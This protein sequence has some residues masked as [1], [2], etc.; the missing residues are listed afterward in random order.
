MYV[1]LNQ[2]TKYFDMFIVKQVPD[3]LLLKRRNKKCTNMTCQNQEYKTQQQHTIIIIISAIAGRIHWKRVF[4][5]LT[6]YLKGNGR[7]N[8]VNMNM[9]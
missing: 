2:I 8:K 5:G 9:M 4:I 6:N 7:L 1:H 3:F